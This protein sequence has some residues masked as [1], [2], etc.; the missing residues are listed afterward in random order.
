M[1]Y[2]TNILKISLMTKYLQNYFYEKRGCLFGHPL[3]YFTSEKKNHLQNDLFYIG[4][5][6]VQKGYNK[7][8]DL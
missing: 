8:L 1:I 2:A 5:Q 7:K 6:R 3:F 4:L